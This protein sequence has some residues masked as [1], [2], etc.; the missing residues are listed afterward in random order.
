MDALHPA[1]VA[2]DPKEALGSLQEADTDVLALE[3]SSVVLGNRGDGC[4]RSSGHRMRRRAFLRAEGRAGRSCRAGPWTH[5]RWDRG[6]GF[7]A[8]RVRSQSSSSLG[9]ATQDRAEE[10]RKNLGGKTSRGQENLSAPD[11]EPVSGESLTHLL[12][13]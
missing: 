12:D 2:Y 6:G 4:L 5:R 9:Q 10:K 13:L 1:T 7:P 11:P 8:C 3:D